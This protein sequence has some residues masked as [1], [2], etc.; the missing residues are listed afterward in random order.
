MST[1][2]A[3][4]VSGFVLYLQDRG[5][6]RGLGL[7]YYFTCTARLLFTCR[8]SRARLLFYLQ[9]EYQFVHRAVIEFLDTFSDYQNF[10]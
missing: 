2:V 1:G 7:D 4:S 3:G 5:L 10:K 8:A 9:E 6:V